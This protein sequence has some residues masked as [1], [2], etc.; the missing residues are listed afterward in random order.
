[1][2]EESFIDRANTLFAQ[3]EEKDERI[4]QI[5]TKSKERSRTYTFEGIPIKIRY[6]IP[7]DVRHLMEDLNPEA[8]LTETEPIIYDLLAKMCLEDPF[9][10]ADVWE[11]LD[12]KTEGRV[13]EVFHEV[14]KMISGMEG[15]TEEQVRNFR[16]KR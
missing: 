16:G 11:M 4:K 8:D 6:S 10:R 15:I 12:E 13:P 1:M 3:L 2:A 7:K 5:V 14:F 9:N